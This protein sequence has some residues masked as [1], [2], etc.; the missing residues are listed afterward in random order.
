MDRRAAPASAP[1]TRR[2]A[3]FISYNRA[4]DGRLA[5]LLRRALHAF[6]KPWYRLRAVR[7]FRD[8]A[9][10][11][12]NDDLR[13]SIERALD[14]SEY[15]I[16]LASPE[17]ARSRWVN[18]EIEYW[19]RTRTPDRLLIV[20]TDG[21]LDWAP[22][23]A[24]DGS[25]AL[26][27]VLRRALTAEP[28]YVDLRW[29][30][31]ADDLSNRQPRF[32][33]SVA[34]LAATLHGRPKDELLGDDVRLHRRT[35]RL[36]GSG[37]VALAMV[38]ILAATLAVVATRAQT[39]AEQQA[40]VATSRYLAGE[41]RGDTADLLDRSLLLGVEAQGLN[42]SA[43]TRGALLDRVQQ[44][45]ELGAF[46]Y[47]GAPLDDVRFSPDGRLI[48]G[49]AQDGTVVVWDAATRQPAAPLD[50]RH[51]SAVD[52][53]AFSPDGRTL[54]SADLSG[55]VLFRDLETRREV[56]SGAVLHPNALAISPDSTVLVVA[57]E[58]G[59]TLFDLAQRR[60][61][62]DLPLPAGTN[63]RQAA[64]TPDG[65]TLVTGDDAGEIRLWARP[66]AAGAPTVSWT[67]QVLARQA[68]PVY[69]LAVGPD[70]AHL[71]VGDGPDVVLWDLRQRRIDGAPLAGTNG[72]VVTLAWTSDGSALIAGGARPVAGDL[73]V[74]SVDDRS[75]AGFLPFGRTGAAT[76]LAVD[77]T[78]ATVVAVGQDDRVRLWGGERSAP[79][80]WTVRGSTGAAT[81]SVAFGPDGR[82]VA[83]GTTRGAV[84]LVDVAGRRPAALIPD[85][86]RGAVTDVAFGPDGT[87][88]VAGSG[89]A[90]TFWD[91]ATGA[92]AGDP[93]PGPA[94]SEID[95][96]AAALGVD[97]GVDLGGVADIAFAPDG[98]SLVGLT[99]G[100]AQ[101]WDLPSG[102]PSGP[103]VPPAPGAASSLASRIALSPD[104][105]LL[106]VASG[107]EG[108]TIA[109]W[110]T[111][112]GRWTGR[113]WGP[114]DGSVTAL[115]FSP[116][117]RTLVAGTSVLAGP[118][119]VHQWDVETGDLRGPPLT[120]F[121]GGVG[122][123]AFTRDGATLVVGSAPGRLALYDTA[124]QQRVGPELSTGGDV[125]D[126]APSPDGLLLADV[127]GS[128]AVGFRD[129]DPASWRDRACAV[130][131]RNLTRAEW[132]RYLGPDVP[133][134]ATCP[135][136]PPAP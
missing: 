90:I 132:D 120:G 33:E 1:P 22:T 35:V 84:Q 76:G 71:A 131:N 26:P 67:S 53:L 44:A 128:P 75:R 64:F 19:L 60:T 82:T 83:T 58:D 110:D 106:A 47:A 28:R 98:R 96:D 48:A 77:P 38:A 61:L 126:V 40:A 20:L 39:R 62:G 4:V 122:S 42:D 41:A 13:A 29:A 114:V 91:G 107:T 81:T 102:Q 123:A 113:S 117:G 129:L 21:T 23:D 133:Y 103:P 79:L 15:F 73:D 17:A 45:G 55:T 52:A 31:T 50:G 2:Y 57:S 99:N 118:G 92:P 14:D 49:G 112:E 54:V 9:S 66:A 136:L 97:L 70:G 105:G 127:D 46:L 95:N 72:N 88:A 37:I 130:A 74:W 69:V 6:A 30:R 5:P 3:A 24:E 89:D 8:D 7:V 86:S 16:L 108:S 51:E 59:A 36:A 87:L 12:A 93:I 121:S 56:G 116:D 125:R 104:G 115:T 63:V 111:G 100:R 18:Q 65:R 101:R 32:R 25:S 134:R 27:P 34:D 68:T 10:L 94:G 135:A 124:T 11:S 85:A 119:A 43:E 80:Q 109:V 78:S